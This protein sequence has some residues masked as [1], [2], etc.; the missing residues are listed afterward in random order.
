MKNTPGGVHLIQLKNK[1][2]KNKQQKKVY[3]RAPLYMLQG[4]LL[5]QLSISITFHKLYLDH[6]TDNR[7]KRLSKLFIGVYLSATSLF[8]ICLLVL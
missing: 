4:F 5:G 7:D 1:T 2:G 3:A 6:L 8:I